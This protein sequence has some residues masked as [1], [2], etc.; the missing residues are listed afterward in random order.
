[1][2]PVVYEALPTKR[3]YSDYSALSA[4]EA[5]LDRTARSRAFILS[6]ASLAGAVGPVA[7]IATSL[8]ER[9]A[10]VGTA[11]SRHTPLQS[12][13]DM[14]AFAR[15]QQADLLVS[16][17]GGSVI[18]GT[19]AVKAALGADLHRT[20]DFEKYSL[21]RAGSIALPEG[22]PPILAVPTTL[23]AAEFTSTAGYTDPQ[24]GLKEGVRGRHLAARSVVLDPELALK[25]PISLWL[26]SGC[27]SI[28]HAVEGLFSPRI[29]PALQNQAATGL[30]LLAKGLRAAHRRPD[31]RVARRKCQQ[32]VW[33]ISDCC[34]HLTMGASHGLGYLLGTI[35]KV[36]HG[37]TS[38][39]L[40]PEVTSWNAETFPE[41]AKVVADAL[42]S[43]TAADGLRQLFADIGMPNG[44]GALGADQS[45]IERIV[46]LAPTHPVVAA[47]PRPFA[48]DAEFRALLER[49]W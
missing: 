44:I 15:E 12:V 43:E 30:A 2:N 23:S 11:L 41:R 8:G 25:T 5:E 47:N 46:N 33:L 48:N 9:C 36:D 18:D 22:G 28:D 19:K 34:I 14:A 24:S 29:A 1:M 35:A 32:A 6:S 16:I 17:G 26:S 40:L 7:A 27:R 42:G 10:A 4:I 21:G 38:A 49:A 45:V 37:M 20:S 3:V 31:N 39:V 13:V